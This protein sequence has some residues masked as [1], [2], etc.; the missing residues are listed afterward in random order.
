[1]DVLI[2]TID[3]VERDAWVQAITSHTDYIEKIHLHDRLV[4]E[5]IEH[6]TFNNTSRNAQ[7]NYP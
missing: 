6:I 1:M 7:A 2:E 3:H 4:E 5:E